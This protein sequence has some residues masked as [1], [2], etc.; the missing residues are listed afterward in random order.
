MGMATTTWNTGTVGSWFASSNWT[1]ANVPASG[2]TAI[3]RSGTPTIDAG[4]LISNETIIVGGSSSVTLRAIGTTFDTGTTINVVGSG[5]AAGP[6]DAV[7]HSEGETTFENLIYLLAP[8]GTLTIDAQPDGTTAGNFHLT[9]PANSTL[10]LVSRESTLNLSGETI[11]NDGTFEV[12]GIV[13]VD[14]GTTLAG[15]GFVVLQAGGKLFVEGGVGTDEA[16]RFEDGTGLLRIAH[17]DLFDAEIEFS[18][19]SGRFDLTDIAVGSV[20]FT[21]G[22]SSGDFGTLTLY[23]GP[24]QTGAVLKQL[25]VRGEQP[26]AAEDFK[27]TDD[28]GGGTLV[29]YN[30]GAVTKLAQPM[31]VPVVA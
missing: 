31:P 13:H 25:K 9:N 29:T 14:A 3:V 8:H 27:P 20:Q 18:A 10:I 30:P 12:D 1:P 16:V 26:L 24:N 28:G 4:S 17:T 6:L 7:L 22:S 11:T 5:S 2:D 23:A 21:S 19:D 15:A